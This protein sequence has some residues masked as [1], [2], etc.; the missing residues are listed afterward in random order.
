MNTP[1]STRMKGTLRLVARN[2]YGDLLEERTLENLIVNTGL[3][4]VTGALSGDTAAPAVMKYVGIGTGT[5]AA[6]AT[7]V[8]LM[9]PAESRVSGTQSRQH[10]TVDNDTY[11]VVALFTMTADRAVTEAGLFSAST[12]GTLGARRVFAV[13][14]IPN[15]GTLQIT[16]QWQ[17]TAS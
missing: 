2:A 13:M 16:W 15:T 7:D 12:S 5:T 1:E 8:A 11:Q 3:A 4:W 9:T 6:E 17:F 10:T 14:N